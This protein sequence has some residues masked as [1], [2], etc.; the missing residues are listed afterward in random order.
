MELQEIVNLFV[1]N[2]VAIAIII[3][4]AFRDWKFMSQ[5]TET[6]TTIKILIEDFEKENNY[7]IK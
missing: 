1:N 4:F 6:L 7:G 3:Y 5:L 2:G